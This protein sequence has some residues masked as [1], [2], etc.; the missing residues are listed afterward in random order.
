MA[1]ALE[2]RELNKRE[3]GITLDSALN[4][5][6]D[7]DQRLP[8]DRFQADEVRRCGFPHIGRSSFES[9]WRSMSVDRGSTRRGLRLFCTAWLGIAPF[10]QVT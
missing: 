2:F 6:A 8:D 10:I 7:S 3:F 9:T 5:V 4:R 1:S